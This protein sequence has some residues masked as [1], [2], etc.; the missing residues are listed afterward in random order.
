MLANVA[1]HCDFEYS[2][3]GAVG[4]SRSSIKEELEDIGLSYKAYKYLILAVGRFLSLSDEKWQDKIVEKNL[5]T[6]DAL[7]QKLI[8]IFGDGKE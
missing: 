5:M 3:F 4:F 7:T 6:E 1:S 2:S 8:A